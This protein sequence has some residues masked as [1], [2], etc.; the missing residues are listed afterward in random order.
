M[1]KQPIMIVMELV[2]GGSLLNYLR[3]SADKLATKAL[4][5]KESYRLHDLT[6]V[7]QACA[8]M[9]L[10]GCPTWSPSNAFTGTWLPGES[11]AIT[12]QVLA[13]LCLESLAIKAAAPQSVCE[14]FALRNCLVG[15]TNI[16]KISDFGMS[17]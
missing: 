8:R 11:L 4:L 6:I 2:P 12:A 9:L 1:Q 10:V 3:T 14:M 17:R 15:D 5:G 13:N 16:V 7:V